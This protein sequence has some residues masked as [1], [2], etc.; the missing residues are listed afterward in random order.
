MPTFVIS[1]WN[2]T[3]LVPKR[4]KHML[5]SVWTIDPNITDMSALE[6]VL[7]TLCFSV[8]KE[9]IVRQ[10]VDKDDGVCLVHLSMAEECDAPRV[11]ITKINLQRGV[12]FFTDTSCCCDFIRK[13]KCSCRHLRYSRAKTRHKWQ[14][15]QS[16]TDGIKVTSVR[17]VFKAIK[18][19]GSTFLMTHDFTTLAQ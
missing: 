12:I 7:V 17:K 5:G 3:F 8:W 16:L 6:D 18:W 15:T 11:S 2:V 14:T 19:W 1:G 10:V 13:L 4:I 9:C